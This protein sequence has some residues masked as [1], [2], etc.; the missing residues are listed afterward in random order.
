MRRVVAPEIAVVLVVMRDADQRRGGPAPDAAVLPARMS[1]DAGDLVVDFMR[2][3]RRGRGRHQEMR[4][5]PIGLQE[6]IVDQPVAVVRPDD[7]RDRHDG[8][9]GARGDTAAASGSAGEASRTTHRTRRATARRKAPPRRSRRAA[10]SPSRTRHRANVRCRT[11]RRS[12]PAKRGSGR[13]RGGPVPQE[14]AV[15]GSWPR[16]SGG[17]AASTTRQ[18]SR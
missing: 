12:R 2:E 17:S 18:L 16:R 6:Q 5:Q 9:S 8:A 3:Q 14:F 4:D 7:R 13:G 1:D 11:S 10:A 15:A